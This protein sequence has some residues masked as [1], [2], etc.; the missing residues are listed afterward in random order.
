MI[1]SIVRIENISIH[2]F[3][4]V[5]SGEISLLNSR[6]DYKA[7]VVGLYGQNGS[8]KTALV[9]AIALLKLALCGQSIPLKYG[10]YINV[11]AESSDLKFVLRVNNP[12]ENSTYTVNY[13][14]S[15]KKEVDSS[16]Q[17]T[18]T[19]DSDI[20]KCKVI[21]FN[22]VLSYSYSYEKDKDDANRKQRVVDTRT[23]DV[24]VPKT[25]YDLLTNKNK[26]VTT[27]LLVAKKLA[28]ATSRSF[29]F[30]KELLGVLRSNCKVEWHLFLFES[31]V[32]YGNFNLFVIN[33]TNSGLISMNALPLA[34]KYEEKNMGA[35]G[36][37]TIPLDGTATIPQDAVDLVKKLTQNMNI[38]LNQLVPGLT[39]SIKE[40]GVQTLKNG[41]VGCKIELISHKNNKEIPLR[42][43][44]DGIKKIIS[45]LQLLIVIYNKSSITVAIDELD[46][47]VFEYLLGELLRIISEKGKGQL[48]FTSHNLRPLETLDKGFIAFTTTNPTNRYIRLNNV[49]TNHNLRDFYYRDI[50]LGEQNEEVYEQTNNYEISLAFREAGEFSGS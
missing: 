3:K 21:I 31:L 45:I 42:Y 30:S 4:N 32:H 44:S 36:N 18:K 34:F 40:L 20:E 49:K 12:K 28:Y 10:D 16:S 15:I 5:V 11:D 14:F 43:E 50:M 35:V 38:V 1:E 47:G 22:E 46:A 41:K 37:L 2:N 23:E 26:A 27:D 13:E 48:V 8:G 25:K 24:F 29:I 9:N 6:K 39:I 7:S 19:T 17:N 33:T